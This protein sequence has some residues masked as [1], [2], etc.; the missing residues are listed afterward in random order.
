MYQIYVLTITLL[1][2]SIMLFFS[3]YYGWK[4]ITLLKFKNYTDTHPIFASILTGST[5][6]AILLNIF[7]PI[8]P[9]PILLGEFCVQLALLFLFIYCLHILL[10][11]REEAHESS[12]NSKEEGEANGRSSFVVDKTHTLIETHKRNIGIFISIITFLHLIY[13]QGI[14]I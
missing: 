3:D 4:Y 13:P 8:S 9:G 2:V 6:V 5:A 1:I 10:H 11:K 7:F 12:N 14:L